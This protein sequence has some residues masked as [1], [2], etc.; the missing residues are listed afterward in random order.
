MNLESLAY[1]YRQTNEL[2]EKLHFSK[3][4]NE[5]FDVVEEKKT[6]RFNASFVTAEQI[7]NDAVS[8]LGANQF[9]AISIVGPQ[10]SGKTTIAEEI[11]KR[12]KAD[13]FK[14]VYALPDDFLPDVNTWVVKAVDEPRAKNCLI[15]DDLS[16]SLDMQPRKVQALI[17]NLV[18]RFRH[19]F[20]GQLLV[21]Y[22]THRL[23][24]APPMLRNS[25]TWIFSAMQAADRDDA[26]EIIGKSKE[27]KD[28]LE[29]LYYFISKVM[30]DGPKH[31]T[32]K[33][34]LGDH[35]MSF[36][37]GTKEDPGD[38]R[39]MAC[40]H[41]G[42]LNVFCSKKVEGSVMDL[43]VYRFAKGVESTMK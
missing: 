35:E 16:Y 13:D 4:K 21:I 6:M 24:A 36:K 26:R 5:S 1:N 39:L 20:G 10:G 34:V 41:S 40:F 27:M 38:G 2:Y 32:I 29:A 33:F 28:R 43:N 12:A 22:I 7:W 37:W 9:Y 11:A 15:I 8:V 30:I 42:R 23:H 17:K 18:S 3:L 25:G 19:V 31:R 14:L